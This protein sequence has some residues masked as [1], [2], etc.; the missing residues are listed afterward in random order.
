MVLAASVG[1][2]LP[3]DINVFPRGDADCNGRIE[4]ADALVILN[5]IVGAPTSG[6]GCV[7]TVR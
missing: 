7:G 6:S 4:A 3:G 2:T 5:H 1:Q